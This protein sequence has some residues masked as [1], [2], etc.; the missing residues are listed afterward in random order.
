M[1]NIGNTFEG[2]N[3]KFTGVW[4]K[5]NGEWFGGVWDRQTNKRT[6]GLSVY[7][8]YVAAKE[9]GEMAEKAAGEGAKMLLP[10]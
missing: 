8:A 6:Y 2:Q 9:G 5:R 7:S 1:A 10:A 3:G 4:Y